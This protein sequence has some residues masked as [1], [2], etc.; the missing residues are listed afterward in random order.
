VISGWAAKTDVEKR[1]RRKRRR[2]KILFTGGDFLINFPI[3]KA[4]KKM[5]SVPI[6]PERAVDTFS[7][8]IHGIV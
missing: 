8:L 4:I 3:P 6:R 1:G 5:A 7:F 2:D